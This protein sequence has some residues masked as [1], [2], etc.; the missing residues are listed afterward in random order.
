MERQSEGCQGEGMGTREGQKVRRD[1]KRKEVEN[2]NVD[3]KI[4]CRR[5]DGWGG[6]LFCYI[7]L[8]YHV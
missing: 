7:L 4:K 8:F 6:A 1:D 3:K 5:E 2:V